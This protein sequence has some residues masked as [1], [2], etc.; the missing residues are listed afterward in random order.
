MPN[1]TATIQ[2]ATQNQ[3]GN[4][5]FVILLTPDDGSA[6]VGLPWSTNDPST[7]VQ[8]A[9]DR[10]FV[11]QQGNAM[12]AFLASFTPGQTITIPTPPTPP[13]PTQAQINLMNF[14]KW[15]NLTIALAAAKDMGWITGNE[16]IVQN[17]KTE[18]MAL[19]STDLPLMF[20]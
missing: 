19:A 20:S 5:D 1:Y 12:A 8:A 17:V 14:E 10:I 7:L 16:T 9:R 18:V 6:V 13:V 11:L 2:S 15:L 4:V 3:N